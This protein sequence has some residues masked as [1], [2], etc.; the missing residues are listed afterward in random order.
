MNC[1]IIAGPESNNW[2]AAVVRTLMVPGHRLIPSPL[3][4]HPTAVAVDEDDA[5]FLQGGA[6]GYQVA[7]MGH[8]GAA[9]KAG[10]R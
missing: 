3:Q 5:G 2:L 7:G 6:D 8:V 10:D 1:R 9:F 4:L